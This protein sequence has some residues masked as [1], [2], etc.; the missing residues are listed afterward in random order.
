MWGTV[1][2]PGSIFVSPVGYGEGWPMWGVWVGVT[3]ATA[4]EEEEGLF[5]MESNR[6]CPSH[7]PQDLP[8]LFWPSF[9]PARF[10][11]AQISAIGP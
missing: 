7:H 1:K 5:L 2:T 4:L 11:Q 10:S 9:C 6:P 3:G 8:K